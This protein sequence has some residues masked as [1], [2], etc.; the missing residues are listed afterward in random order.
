MNFLTQVEYVL[1]AKVAKH[2]LVGKLN[3]QIVILDAPHAQHQ[4]ELKFVPIVHPTMDFLVEPA[5]FVQMDRLP[6]ED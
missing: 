2:L 4:A 3:A 5:L 6:Q 1:N